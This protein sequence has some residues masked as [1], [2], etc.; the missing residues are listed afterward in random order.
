MFKLQTHK[1]V[2]SDK[3]NHT[4]TKEKNLN[5]LRGKSETPNKSSTPQMSKITRIPQ[6]HAS[7][8]MKEECTYHQRPMPL[9]P[10]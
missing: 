6:K 4:Y 3:F 1:T 5:I 8:V 7:S 10:V 2:G 9:G